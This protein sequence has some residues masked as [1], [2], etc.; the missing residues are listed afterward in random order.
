M[1]NGNAVDEQAF[2]QALSGPIRSSSCV[3][4]AARTKDPC[5]WGAR[6]LRAFTPY[7]RPAPPPG[8]FLCRLVKDNFS[9]GGKKEE[10]ER[11]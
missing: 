1:V 5:H 6:I 9:E 10:E 11:K 2:E 4:V 7:P 3:E 8:P